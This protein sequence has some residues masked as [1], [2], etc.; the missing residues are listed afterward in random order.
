MKTGLAPTT[1]RWPVAVTIA[2]LLVFAASF[3]PWG[4]I[5]YYYT[6]QFMAN[7]E[8]PGLCNYILT[9]DD[10]SGLKLG[11]RLIQTASAWKSG[12]MIL[13]FFVP[14]WLL[15]VVSVFLFA[16]VVFNFFGRLSINTSIP[17]LLSFCGLI[18]VGESA[19]GFLSQGS[20]GWGLVLT[21]IGYLIFM[22]SF[23]RWRPG[24]E[25]A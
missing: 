6:S 23:L 1:K 2:F 7:M 9:D 13:D 24:L 16:I 3:L 8:H 25:D 20:I 15:A 22:I 17:Q 11:A 10:L 19:L 4:T 12:F 18:Y 5:R 21:G 14:H